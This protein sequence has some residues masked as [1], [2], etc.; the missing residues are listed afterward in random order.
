[1]Q[2]YSSKH[3]FSADQFLA[4][5]TATVVQYEYDNITYA[6][7]VRTLSEKTT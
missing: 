6:Y 3:D 7:T 4:D 5:R 2:Y 1:M